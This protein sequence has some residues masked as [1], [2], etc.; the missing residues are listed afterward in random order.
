MGIGV[1]GLK[2]GH[3]EAAGYGTVV[4]TA[5]GGRRLI[6]VLHGL[7]SMSQRAEEARK[8]VTWGTRGFELIPVFAAG[9]EVARAAVYGGVSPDVGLVGKGNIDL[10][11]PKGAENCPT[12]TV[13]YRGPLMPPVQAGEEVGTL[14]VMCRGVVVQTTPL[15]AAEAV[16]EGD[17]VRRSM[18][19][20][21]ELALGWL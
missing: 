8:L 20:L 21:K 11:I 13:T 6:A 12:A 19:A 16:A 14:N 2:T 9:E 18:D 1:D 5:A 4:S 7:E 10:F 17:I 15:Y 3:T